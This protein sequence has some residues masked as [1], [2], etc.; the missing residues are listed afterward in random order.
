MANPRVRVDFG[1]PD[2]AAAEPPVRPAEQLEAAKDQLLEAAK[3]TGVEMTDEGFQVCLVQSKPST[4]LATRLV[5]GARSAKVTR[6]EL[7][8]STVW[9]A[10]SDLGG[11]CLECMVLIEAACTA[12]GKRL[13]H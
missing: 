9:S 10:L 4:V 6:S 8:D 3:A 5:H 1:P 12:A 11:S 2:M 13:L 7:T